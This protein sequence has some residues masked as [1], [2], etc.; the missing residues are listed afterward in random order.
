MAI[1]TAIAAG[2]GYLAA[3]GAAYTGLVS[4]SLATTIGTIAGYAV[5]GVAASA[6]ARALQPNVSVPRA[7]IQATLSQTSAA[8][9]VFVGENL[10]GGIRA[11]FDVRDGWLY[12]LVVVSHGQVSEFIS[13]RVDGE[14]VTL[15]G[16]TFGNA[17]SG[18]IAGYVQTYTRNGSAFGGDYTSL[19]EKFDYWDSDRRLEAQA[20]FIVQA[21]APN[22]EDFNK[23]FPKGSNT[24]FQWVIRGQEVEDPRGGIAAY[25]DN[26]ALV[27]N[28]Y[29]THADGFR[30]DP[31]DIDSD[32]V[33]AMADVSDALIAQ[34]D[35]TTAPSLRLW[36]HWSMDET[37][38][39]V[40]DRMT[41]SSGIRVYERQDGKIGL[42]GG[43]FGE[44]ACTLTAKDIKSI[45][46]REAIS[47]REGYNV[48]Q[49]FHLSAEQ[50]YEEI[51]VAAWR[52]EA[53]LAQEGEILE[54][55]HLEMCP[56]LSQARRLAKRQMH[57]DNRQGITLVTN[58]VGLKARFP[59]AAGQRHTILLD[60]RP[61]DGSGRVIQG[62]YEVVDHAFDPIE[63]ECTIDLKRVD[64]ASVEW[65]P[66]EEGETT[67]ALPDSS[68][69]APEIS[70][71]LTQRVTT[72]TGGVQQAALEVEAVAVEDREDLSVR[73]QYRKVGTTQWLDMQTT[74]YTAISAA[75][76]DG[77]AY[78]VQARWNG[79]F[80]GV[81]AWETLGP[82]TI[83]INGT[84]PDA[85]SELIPSVGAAYVHLSWRNPSSAF[86]EIRIYRNTAA[87][88]ATAALVGRTGGT[89][90]QLS[91]FE[92]STISAATDYWF[93]V[94]AA[95]S[96]GV[97]ST[98]AG[99]AA[100]TTP[101]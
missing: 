48:L 13:F 5:A 34:A 28:H 16:E 54:E 86:F 24:V 66:S 46:T 76:E 101:V 55:M 96:S 69:P 80:D 10:V 67:A 52:D 40:M 88:F 6:I 44:P 8:R 77:A 70:A 18:D 87:D 30:L 21:K 38:S 90:G 23:V 31:A 58:A 98:P 61:E 57:D 99:P 45:Q 94:V 65:D 81:D 2:V 97:E 56:D 33:A 82:I 14:E 51:E 19:L 25:S 92:D 71:A 60:Y 91:E 63:L 74:V 43:G 73:A 12:Q 100:I 29:L 1:F 53:R 7:E 68:N 83:Q 84:A 35:G 89:Q 9:R 27:I 49:V 50:N 62:E 72:L 95:N 36:G 11:L 15:D 41:L 17:T 26:A 85:P 22:A 78:E 93:W 37:P 42:I 47:E 39:D 79:V 4:I 32:S 64:R 75:V 20:T 3:Y 59:R